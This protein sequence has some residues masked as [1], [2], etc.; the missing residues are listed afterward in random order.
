MPKAKLGAP[1]RGVVSIKKT[2][3]AMASVDGSSAEITLYGDIYESQPTDWFGNPIEGQFILL[4]EFL[5]DLKAIEN[6]KA[7][8]IRMNSYGGDAGVS[9]TIHN[10][11]REL[12]RNGADV[13][14]VVDGVAMSGGSL[15][16]CACDTVRVNPSSLIM[17][18]KGWSFLWGGYNADEL[19]DQA[20]TMDAWDKMQVEIYKRKTGMS[21]TVLI[22]MMSDT[23]YMTGREAKEKGFADEIMEDAEPISIAASADGRSLFVRGRQMHL[24]PGMFAP[25]IIPTVTPAADA[26]V[27]TNTNTPVVT[28]SEEGGNSMT[29]EELRTQ[30]PD[31]IASVEAAARAAVDNTDAVNAAVQAERE[32]IAGIDEVAALFDPA[33][34]YE[35]KYGESPCTAAEMTLKAAQSAAKKGSKFLAD[36]K[37][38]AEASG[39]ADV[40]GVPGKE[41]M[42]EDAATPE[43]RMNNAR[44]Q[45]KAALG[46]KEG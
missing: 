32:R 7:I 39:A 26:A 1:L 21:E 10:R 37:E 27:E 4:D 16:M 42:D 43:A 15:I 24:A 36:A 2:A 31:Q 46:K 30:Y 3:Y 19:R 35:A 6:C 17:I 44:A 12:S 18:H 20:K 23:T 34:V 38:D 45:V 29:V 14:C 25:D 41:D 8:T 33:I 13:S 40:K 28:G 11:L 9:N 22:H 5:E